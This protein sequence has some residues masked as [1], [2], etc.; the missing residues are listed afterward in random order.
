MNETI[1]FL[2][3]AG[4][5]KRLSRKGWILK[6]VP[7][8]ES[9]ADHSF[10]TA[11]M[12]MLLAKKCGCDEDK[13]VKMALL[14]D[15]A[16]AIAGDITPGDM[17]PNRKIKAEKA[18]A[19]MLFKNEAG[20]KKIWQEYEAQKSPEAKFV[21]ELDKLEMMMQAAEYENKHSI[22]LGEL[23]SYAKDRIKAPELK[24]IAAKL[25]RK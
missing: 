8:P 9:V 7:N 14:H 25:K 24:K 4:K 12:A 15:L 13:C 3:K 23:L 22:D 11:V 16:E 19:N 21:Y 17:T 18:A 5:L 1:S 10:R 6:K 2:Q 20:L